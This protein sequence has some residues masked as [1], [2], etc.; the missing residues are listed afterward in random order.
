MGAMLSLLKVLAVIAVGARGLV[1]L[2]NRDTS[3]G[4]EHRM[5]CLSTKRSQKPFEAGSNMQM[6]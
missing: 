5:H 1:L 4:P 3:I 2:S 6:H